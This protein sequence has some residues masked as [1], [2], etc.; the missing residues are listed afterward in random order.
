M[1]AVLRAAIS[2]ALETRGLPT[3]DF[4]IEHP[5]MLDHGD[6]ACNVAMVLAKQVGQSPRAIAEA[7]AA[8]LVGQIEYVER[9]E[10]AG[11]G[12][13]N[14]Y[15]SRDFFSAEA[16]RAIEEGA[17][18]GENDAELDE[19]VLFEYTSPNLFKPLHIGNLVGN[20]IGESFTRLFEMA[21]A[22]VRRMNYPSDIGMTVAKGVWGLRATGSDPHD[23]A[24]LGQSYRVGNEAFENDEA[25]KAEIEAINKAL[26]AGTDAELSAL[27]EAGIATSRRSL[28][29]ICALLGTHF[30]TE[31]TESQAS[32]PGTEIVK[33]NIGT[34]FTESEGAVVYEGEKVGLH[35]RVF[36]NSQGLPT[37][38]A[39]DV[40]HFT[41]K[42]A[43]HP[44]WTQ[45][46][47]VTGNEQT[48]YFKV[49]YAALRELFPE[50]ADKNL[51][52]IPTG[53]LTLTTGKMSS[54]KG[55]VLTGESLL[56]EVAE[57]A[58]ER[59][60]ESRADDID[61]LTNQLAVAAIKY[62][63]LRYSVGSNIVFDKEKALS[64]EG[65]SG[66]YL[67]YTY[68]RALSV[69]EKARGVGVLPQLTPAPE[70]PYVLERILYRFPEVVEEALR[71]RAPHTVVTYLT[72]LAGEFNSFYAHEKIADKDDV[73]APYKALLTSAIAITLKNG[74]WV[75]GIEAPERL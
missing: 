4:A 21:G 50:I 45:S 61:K 59:A 23:I 1:D 32:Q 5:K 36:L 66:P 6:Y 25:A 70:T 35:T 56:A 30:D 13:L 74:L 7:L 43:A 9:I 75:L 24:A 48:E 16:V 17:G 33:A 2:E 39:K 64:F 69:L 31:I 37:Y 73:H 15:L 41:L 44:D 54:R 40:G 46:I 27:R 47:I 20:I 18:W 72:E 67:Q 8:D 63:I 29:A 11:P 3:C 10:I 14:F 19:V 38:E 65:D 55:N 12:F 28:A 42:A 60:S 53:F 71:E 26:Y 49:L 51:E 57:A 68:A 22:D 62:Q 52:H 34:V 58:R